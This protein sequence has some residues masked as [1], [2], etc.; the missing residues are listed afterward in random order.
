MEHLAGEGLAAV[1]LQAAQ[2]KGLRRCIIP[3]AVSLRQ[4]AIAESEPSLNVSMQRVN[5]MRHSQA[6]RQAA[7]KPADL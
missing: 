2:M 3:V 6:C 4:R 5:S 7:V 1:G